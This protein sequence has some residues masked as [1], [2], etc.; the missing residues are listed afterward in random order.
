[1]CI[2]DRLNISSLLSATCPATSIGH[3]FL[4]FIAL[5]NCIH[6]VRLVVLVTAEPRSMPSLIALDSTLRVSSSRGGDG[7]GG[8]GGGG[9]GNGGGGGACSGGACSGGACSGGGGGSMLRFNA[10]FAFLRRA[11][12]GGGCGDG[13]LQC[14]RVALSEFSDRTRTRTRLR[15]FTLLSLPRF[16]G[17]R[18]IWY[19]GTLVHKVEV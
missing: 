16:T 13:D 18:I 8:T 17:S 19:L 15:S 5:V 9:D 6:S 11:G 10:F 14:T 1:M 3:F 4:L 7:N 12:D 2:R